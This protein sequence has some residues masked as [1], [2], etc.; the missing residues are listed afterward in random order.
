MTKTHILPKVISSFASEA[1]GYPF[2][3][4]DPMSG[5]RGWDSTGLS[6]FVYFDML[7]FLFNK[8]IIKYSPLCVTW[9]NCLM[10]LSSQK[11]ISHNEPDNLANYL[12]PVIQN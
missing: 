7:N 10:Q 12:G 1:L 6:E 2:I 5:F 9:L 4:Q 8:A 11:L 3:S